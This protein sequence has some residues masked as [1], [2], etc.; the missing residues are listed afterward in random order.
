VVC[1][2]LNIGCLPKGTK[3]HATVCRERHTVA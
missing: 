3:R 2:V 1:T